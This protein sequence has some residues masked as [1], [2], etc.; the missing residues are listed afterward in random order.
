MRI[1]LNL[2]NDTNTKSNMVMVEQ[3]HTI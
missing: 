3:D 2:V 1:V